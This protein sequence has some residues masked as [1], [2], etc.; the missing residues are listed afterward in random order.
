M[1][2][3]SLVSQLSW[4][5]IV[6]GA[7]MSDIEIRTA[8]VGDIDDL[9]HLFDAYRVFYQQP[10]DPARARAFLLE[11]FAD[12]GSIVFLARRKGEPAGF[13]QMFPSF[14]SVST[15]RIWILNDLYVAKNQR[16]RGIARALMDHAVRW[17]KENSSIRLVLETATDNHPAKALYESLGWRMETGFDRYSIELRVD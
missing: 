9:S 16:H 13:V 14:S 8:T 1:P 12:G 17:A 11:R 15:A 3:A 6:G 2:G 4:A 7:R 10:G 5:V